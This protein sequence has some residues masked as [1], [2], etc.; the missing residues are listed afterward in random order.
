MIL[1]AT[2]LLGSLIDMFPEISFLKGLTPFKYFNT[3]DVLNQTSPDPLMVVLTV[4][5]ASL[6]CILTFK[7]YEKRDMNI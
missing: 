7:G 2:Y 3:V 5:L 4:V 1:V 6:L